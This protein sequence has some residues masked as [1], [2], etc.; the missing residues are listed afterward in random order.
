MVEEMTNGVPERYSLSF[1]QSAKGYFY[2]EKVIV[3][4]ASKEDLLKNMEYL[5]N[6]I[7]RRLIIMNSDPKNVVE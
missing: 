7:K 4:A 5:L 2:C 1:T 6:E 3:E